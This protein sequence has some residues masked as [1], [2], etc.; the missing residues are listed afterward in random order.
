MNGAQLHLIL[1][2][3]PVMGSLFSLLLLLWGL[4]RKNSEIQKVAFGAMVIVAFT[5][6]FAYLTGEPAEEVLEAVPQFDGAYVEPH[7]EMAALALYSAIG[8]GIVA[9]VSLVLTRGKQVPLGIA[10]IG[11]L[12]NLG[13]AGMMGYTAHLGGMIRHTEI[14]PTTT[15]A[16]GQAKQEAGKEAHERP[17]SHEN[18]DE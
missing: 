3:L 9:L 13:V 5:A 18:H 4:I 16:S 2:H 12:A 17:E 8:M 1:N 15:P 14:R 7:E 10:L 11:L 6:Y